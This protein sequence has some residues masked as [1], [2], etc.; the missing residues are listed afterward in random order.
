[1][2]LL[3]AAVALSTASAQQSSALNGG[4][5]LRDP[6]QT[7]NQDLQESTGK[8]LGFTLEERTRW[9]EK[10]GVTFGKAVDQQD[11]LSRLRIGAQ[12]QP[13]GWLRVY[14]MGQ[15]SRVGFYGITA[16]NTLRDTIDLQ[17]SYV[18]FLGQ[19]KT[20]FGAAFG[21]T[22]LNY[23][24]TRVIGTPQWS[25]VARTYDNARLYY[26]TARARYE[27]LMVSPVKDTHGSVIGASKIARVF[28]GVSCKTVRQPRDA[29]AAIFSGRSSM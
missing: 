7:L 4:S 28:S 8:I 13:T 17:E 9:E 2:A 5:G 14:A 18:E 1:M 3:A 10:T 20:G 29:P 12:F 21:R 11:V 24:E 26:R 19:R 15:D 27:I 16:P 22:M 23:G 6:L 25:N